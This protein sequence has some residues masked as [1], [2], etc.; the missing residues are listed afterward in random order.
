MS[1]KLKTLSASQLEHFL[2]E[3]VNSYLDEECSCSVSKLN[4]PNINS[5]ADTGETDRRSIA[6]EVHLIYKDRG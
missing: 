3:K 2:T 1:N 4:T 5:E 6:F